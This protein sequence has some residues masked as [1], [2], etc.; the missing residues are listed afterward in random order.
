M[1]MICVHKPVIKPGYSITWLCCI[2][3]IRAP[4]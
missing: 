3:E 2:Q 4:M 1:K